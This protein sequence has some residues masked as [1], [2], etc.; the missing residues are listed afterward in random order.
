M[1]G[2]LISNKRVPVILRLVVIE[3]N[4]ECKRIVQEQE[5]S[6]GKIAECKESIEKDLAWNLSSSFLME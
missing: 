2:C 1:W 4:A 3:L 6:R 5:Y